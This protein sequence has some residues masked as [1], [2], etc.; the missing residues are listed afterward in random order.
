[1][2]PWFADG[3]KGVF[4]NERGLTDKEIETI[5][6]WVNGGAPAGDKS[7]APAPVQFADA[8]QRRLLARQA[9]PDRQDAA[10]RPDR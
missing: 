9:R 6:A 5:L 7:K 3:P 1:M 4:T 2:P 10:V 8:E